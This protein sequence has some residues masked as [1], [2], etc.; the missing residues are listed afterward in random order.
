AMKTAMNL[1]RCGDLAKNVAKRTPQLTSAPGAALAK[2]VGD[3]G[4]LVAKR[5]GE[6]VAAYSAEDAEAA[7]RVWE[8]DTDIDELHEK[9]FHQI[10]RAMSGDPSSI[11]ASTHL[12]FITKNLERIGDH[13]TNIAELVCYQVT[14]GEL[15]DRPK[16]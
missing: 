14:G 16:G 13:A 4:A 5:L 2:G 11:E 15:S 8:K 12:L 6:V 3:L 10:L 7:Q 9:V 1:E